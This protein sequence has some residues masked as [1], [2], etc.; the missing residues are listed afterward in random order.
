METLKH[1]SSRSRHRAGDQH[2]VGQPA[3]Q[4]SSRNKSDRCTQRVT[5]QYD[6]A[7]G[8]HL[9]KD[10][11]DAMVD[12]QAFE[13]AAA[14]AVREQVRRKRRKFQQTTDGLPQPS[15]RVTSM[16]EDAKD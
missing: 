11:I 14:L 12:G 3:G 7:V 10:I 4:A 6:M 15:T 13:F 2:E 9:R 1:G 16:N 8:W 5:G